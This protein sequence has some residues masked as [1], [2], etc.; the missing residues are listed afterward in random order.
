MKAKI[1][2]KNGYVSSRW[3]D[4]NRVTEYLKDGY[5]IVFPSKN[6]YFIINKECFNGYSREF[7]ETYISELKKLN[8]I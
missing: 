2:S 1:L 3:G 5:S 7:I 8:I 6:N 4:L